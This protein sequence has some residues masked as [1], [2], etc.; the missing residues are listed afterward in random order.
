MSEGHAF[1]EPER[2]Y[3]PINPE[4]VWRSLVRKLWAPLALAVGLVLKFGA[5]TFKFFGIFISVGGYALI[6]GWRFAVGFVALILVHELGHFVEAKR[7][8]LHPSLPVFIPFLGAYV[9]MRNAPFDPWR[10]LLV[11]A[12]GPIAGGLAAL[13]VW[14]YGTATDSR[15]LVA[16]A[17]VGFL[18]NLINL[19][20][21]RPLD[22]GFMWQSVKAL[23]Y[24]ARER[25]P[26]APRWRVPAS[27]LVYG[28]LVVGLALAMWASHIP[29]D[30][31]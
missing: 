26:W 2:E 20:P 13:A 1:P 19:I 21:F 30:R 17:Y 9:A 29:Q 24:G 23:R 7:Q 31:L 4:P 10:N 3:R 18:L 22:G 5:A 15:F 16:L 14:G 11:S 6:W 8:G 27:A 28:G 12:A 25:A